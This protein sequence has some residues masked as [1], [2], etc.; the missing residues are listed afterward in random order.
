MVFYKLI[1]QEGMNVF[2]RYFMLKQWLNYN[3]MCGEMIK[4]R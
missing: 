3:F 4:T 2:A 1:K